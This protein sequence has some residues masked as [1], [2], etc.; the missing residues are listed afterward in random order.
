MKRECL[1]L[2]LGV[3]FSCCSRAEAT[4]AP[5]KQRVSQESL[6]GDT[7]RKLLPSTPPVLS[8][9]PEQKRASGHIYQRISVL[10]DR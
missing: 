4:P 7:Q 5:A 1:I 3:L 8:P 2:C 9:Q 10:D 6:I